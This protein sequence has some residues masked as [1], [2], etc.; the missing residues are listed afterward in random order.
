MS[1]TRS[2]S[3]S[4]STSMSMSRPSS[5]YS[6]MRE[7]MR[8]GPKRDKMRMVRRANDRITER[9]MDE[10][11]INQ[12]RSGGRM[13][14][15]RIMLE[16]Q[17]TTHNFDQNDDRFVGELTGE[18]FNTDDIYDKGMPVRSSFTVKKSKYDNNAHL[19]F[20]LFEKVDKRR[21]TVQYSDTSAGEYAGLDEAMKPITKGA[22]PYETCVSSIS[23]TT[24]W[25]HS[26]MFEVS[27]D[28]Y[29]V[30]GLG[31]FSSFGVI[32]LVGRGNTEIELKNYFGFQDKRH[33]N[34]GLLTVREEMNRYRDQVVIDNFIIN[35]KGVPSN[36]GVASKLK[37][38][39]FN[40]V[41]NRDYPEQEA[42]RVNNI[43]K[44]VSR[45]SDVVSSNT[46]AKSNVSLVTLAKVSPIWA[47]KVDNVIKGRSHRDGEPVSFIRFMGKTFD[48]YED[49][50]RQIIEV[51]LYGDA[52]VVGLIMNKRGLHEPTDLKNLTTSLNYMKPTVLDEVMIPIVKKR[53][54]TR[55]N[56]TLQHTG[57]NVTFTENDVNAL[58][59]EGGAIDDCIQYVDINFGTRSANKRCDNRGYRT[60]RKFI[61]N[62]EFEF[63][64]RHVETN[65]I[66]MMGRM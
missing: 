30:N 54:K 20:N 58:Y 53:Y 32:Y 43:I 13:D 65:C 27:R 45:M 15:D 31:L 33:L 49:A 29:V 4:S 61:C 57:L 42:D 24:C 37:K 16:R 39:I 40:V 2:G 55:L 23:E 1:Y 6:G 36:G 52:L 48:H 47:Y 51:P 12:R 62:G 38:L 64:L 11:E 63:Y 34:A 46:L 19:D 44:T 56:K 22:D 8:D 7:G 28:D 26:N 41:I 3:R 10:V 9:E 5:E 14:V 35:D 66:M 21:D 25:M 60:T 59:P 18:E 50:E 17:M